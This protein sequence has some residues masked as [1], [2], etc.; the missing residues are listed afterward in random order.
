[1]Y[2][3]NKYHSNVPYSIL[4]VQSSS[5]T[6]GLSKAKDLWNILKFLDKGF[7]HENMKMSHVP[8]V[9]SLDNRTFF[10]FFFC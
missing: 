7:G 4:S 9:E 1:M 6:F 3:C 5:R 2:S 8:R 10:F